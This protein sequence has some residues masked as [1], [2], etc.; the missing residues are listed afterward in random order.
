MSKFPDRMDKIFLQS[1]DGIAGLLLLTEAS[2]E[3]LLNP[4][5]GVHQIV[6]QKLLP[7]DGNSQHQVKAIADFDFKEIVFGASSNLTLDETSRRQAGI[8][9]GAVRFTVLHGAV[10]ANQARSRLSKI[11]RHNDSFIGLLLAGGFVYLDASGNILQANR[12]S[13]SKEAAMACPS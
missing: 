7:S 6:K 4:A 9:S 3:A 10:R 8:P 13:D 1:V 2:K 5:G 12:F 11:K